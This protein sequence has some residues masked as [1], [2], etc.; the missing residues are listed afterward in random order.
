MLVVK[1]V[2]KDRKTVLIFEDDRPEVLFRSSPVNIE[3]KDLF[4]VSLELTAALVSVLVP[5]IH[6][7]DS[8]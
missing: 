4:Q 7:E 6:H 1:V 5:A 2:K 8:E 3:N